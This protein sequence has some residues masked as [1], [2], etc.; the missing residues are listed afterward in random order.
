[1]LFF[2]DAVMD[3]LRTMMAAARLAD[4][5]KFARARQELGFA[6]SPGRAAVGPRPAPLSAA[7]RSELPPG[8]TAA[9]PD[10]R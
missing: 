6:A 2:T 7:T 8:P 1:M 10:G 3:A 5:K 4:R 9:W